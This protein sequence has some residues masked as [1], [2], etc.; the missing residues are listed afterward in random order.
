MA[1]TKSDAMV[2]H[3]KWIAW[4]VEHNPKQLPGKDKPVNLMPETPVLVLV[5]AAITVIVLAAVSF[6]R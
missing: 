4:V 5:F 2:Q 3:E 6:M 1:V